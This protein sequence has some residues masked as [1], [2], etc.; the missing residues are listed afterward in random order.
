MS[1]I[2][3]T[4]STH[5]SLWHKNK[6]SVTGMTLFSLGILLG[7]FG[8]WLVGRRVSGQSIVPVPIEDP[9]TSIFIPYASPS[10]TSVV[11]SE[12]GTIE[13]WP[14]PGDEPGVACTMEAKQ[15]PDGSYVGR[16]PPS[17]QFAPCPTSGAGAS[18]GS[19]VSGNAGSG[20]QMTSPAEPTST[21]SP[22]F[23]K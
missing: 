22:I 2:A 11:P 13:P 20:V 9:G 15:C 3:S 21:A 23:K 14:A 12:P 19:G 10:P 18:S 8:G 5:T 1:E 16:Q 6:A 17:C 4:A 7:F